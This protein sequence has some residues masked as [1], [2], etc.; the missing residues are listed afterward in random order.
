MAKPQI[1]Y[2]RLEVEIIFVFLIAL[3][4]MTAQG[5]ASFWAVQA[6]GSPQCSTDQ[7]FLTQAVGNKVICS[8]KCAGLPC[9]TCRAFNFHQD[10]SSCE[11]FHL[12]TN[13]YGPRPGCTLYQV[14][15]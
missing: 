14:S 3:R 11:L 8:L 2:T 10:T 13:N 9:G 6:G 5:A 7:P 1:H 12:V 4:A 15:V